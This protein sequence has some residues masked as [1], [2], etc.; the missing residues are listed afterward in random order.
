MQ[1]DFD[2]SF[3]L[4]SATELPSGFVTIKRS[5]SPGSIDVPKNN[6]RCIVVKEL[7]DSSV[8]VV[9]FGELK[10]GERPQEAIIAVGNEGL[11]P[12]F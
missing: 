7:E 9:D 2:R 3:V 6:V 8:R 12:I 4:D 11:L 10:R 1:F 5:F